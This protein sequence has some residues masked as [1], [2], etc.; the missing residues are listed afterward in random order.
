MEGRERRG[1]GGDRKE[2]EELKGR[3]SEESRF[4]FEI[5]EWRGKE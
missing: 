2:V 4:F 3:S 5:K 1:R